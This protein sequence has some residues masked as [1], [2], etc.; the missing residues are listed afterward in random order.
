MADRLCYG[1]MEPLEGS[2]CPRCGWHAGSDNQPHQ[3]GVGTLLRDQYVI[4]RALGQGGFGITYLGWDRYLDMKVAVKEFYPSALV[5]RDRAYGTGVFTTAENG[6][7]AFRASLERFLREAKALARFEGVPAIVSIKSFF[8]ANGTAYIIMEYVKGTSLEKFVAL[9]GGRLAPEEAFRLLDPVI[10]ALAKVHEAGM[11]HRDISP[12]NIILHP[13]GG[14]KL[15]DFGAVREVQDPRTGQRDLKSTE[16][17]LKHGFAPIEQY[18]SKG[19]L[20][21]WTDVYAFCGTLFYCLTGRVPMEATQRI[22]DGVDLPWDQIPGLSPHHQQVLRKGTALRAADRYAGMAQLKQALTAAPTATPRPTP[23]PAQRPTPPVPAPKPSAPVPA[24]V[25]KPPAP[26]SSDWICECGY[27]NKSWQ[28]SCLSCGKHKPDLPAPVPASVKKP[29]APTSSDWICECGYR[30]KSWQSSCLSCGKHKPE[31][32]APIPASVKKPPA[33]TSS[34]WICECGY[35][36]K[37][38]HTFCQSCGKDL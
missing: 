7:V 18:Q 26:T 4:G 22:L 11:V 31:L 30:N 34:D 24:S 3:L 36:N 1:C 10:D 35:R 37:S 12:D 9:R 20:G 38:W 28:S 6:A 23:G 16:A 33:P 5:A 32:P 29:P 8:E 15:L 14:A 2:V 25:K 13:M 19:D 27:R 21:P 17:I